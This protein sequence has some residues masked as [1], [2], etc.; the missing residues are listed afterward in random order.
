MITTEQIR[1]RLK[2]AIIQSGIKKTEIAKKLE[3]ATKP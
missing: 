3:F 2:E 1:N